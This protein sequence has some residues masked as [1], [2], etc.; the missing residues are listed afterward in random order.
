MGT[1]YIFLSK[2]DGIIWNIYINR[3]V[4]SYNTGQKNSH[5]FLSVLVKF[6]KRKVALEIVLKE[7]NILEKFSLM[8]SIILHPS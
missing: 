3:Y 1:L 7:Q 4:V 5:I 2:L 6:D 8:E